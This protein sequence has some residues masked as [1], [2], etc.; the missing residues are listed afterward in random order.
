MV[1]STSTWRRVTIIV[2]YPVKFKLRQMSHLCCGI[3]GS[4]CNFSTVKIIQGQTLWINFLNF[5]ASF[6]TCVTVYYVS[7]LVKLFN[8]FLSIREVIAFNCFPGPTAKMFST[9]VLCF[10]MFWIVFIQ[11]TGSTS[12]CTS[13]LFICS[14]SV[15]GSQPV[16][17]YTVHLG[18]LTETQSNT[19]RRGSWAGFISM[20]WNAPLTGMSWALLMPC[21][22]FNSAVVLLNSPF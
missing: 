14:T 3:K 1:V 11:F 2:F 22:K 18:I 15:K 5:E 16:P 13:N 20:V 10:I 6:I 9:L 4:K 21:L 19:C 12:C 7:K 17:E 8:I